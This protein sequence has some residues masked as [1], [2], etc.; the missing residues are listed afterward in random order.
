MRISPSLKYHNKPTEV[1]GF[2]FDSKMEA[3][4]YLELKLMVAAGD[5][6][7]LQLHPTYQ[8]QSPFLYKGKQVRAIIYEADF[9]YAEKTE[10]GHKLVV[11]DVKGSLTKEFRIKEKMFKKLYGAELELRLITK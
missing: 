6:Q 1:D 11:E 2:R 4:R 3:A 5:I 9:A 10:E 8:L 7:D